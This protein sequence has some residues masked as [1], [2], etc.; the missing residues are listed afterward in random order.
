MACRTHCCESERAGFW[1]ICP[2]RWAHPNR[3]IRLKNSPSARTLRMEVGLG[4]VR[5]RSTLRR[6]PSP[7]MP[8][9]RGLQAARPSSSRGVSGSECPARSPLCSPTRLP[10]R[11]THTSTSVAHTPAD[12]SLF[13]WSVQPRIPI[14]HTKDEKRFLAN[15]MFDHHTWCSCPTQ[16]SRHTRNLPFAHRI[17]FRTG[18]SAGVP[19]RRDRMTHR[20]LHWP[21][22]FGMSDHRHRSQSIRPSRTTC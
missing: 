6:S 9:P 14:H 22:G 4:T 20:A 2:H 7:T 1:S 10:S 19:P 16:T 8:L 11:S 12:T 15:G 21:C 5:Y 18:L 17:V 3:T 13:A